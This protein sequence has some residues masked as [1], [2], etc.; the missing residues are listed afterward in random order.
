MNK[1]VVKV[2]FVSFAAVGVA[3]VALTIV[4]FTMAASPE[5]TEYNWG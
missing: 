4:L 2:A 3:A 1:K 5:F